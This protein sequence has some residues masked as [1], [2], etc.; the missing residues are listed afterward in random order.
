MVGIY[1]VRTP[2]EWLQC[3]E[4]IK[5]FIKGQ[6]IMDYDAAYVLVKSLLP[7]DT[8]QISHNKEKNHME[9]SSPVFMVCIGVVTEHIF[10][11]NAYKMQKKYIHNICKPL[12]VS[13]HELISCTIKLN[14]SLE[15]SPCLQNLLQPS[16]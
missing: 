15:N 11:T 4:A 16:Y 14:D 7:R 5:Q 3:V 2:K 12:L 9:N 8:L 10:P 13:A 1:K 6:D